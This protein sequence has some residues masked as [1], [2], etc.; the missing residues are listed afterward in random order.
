VSAV[1]DKG[2]RPGAAV[3]AVSAGRARAALPTVPPCVGCAPG[4]RLIRLS[5]TGSRATGT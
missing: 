2:S 1:W 4:P 5:C 3:G